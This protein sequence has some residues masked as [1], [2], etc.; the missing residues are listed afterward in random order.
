MRIAV[1]GGGLLGVGTALELARRG[2]LVDLFEQ[3]DDLLTQ[4]AIRNEG[5]IHLGYVYAN[6]GFETAAGMVQGALRFWPLLRRWLGDAIDRVP[7]SDGF[8][9]L[10]HRD[11]LVS[12][13]QV[14]DHARRVQHLLLTCGSALDYPGGPPTELTWLPA[15]AMSTVVDDRWVSATIQ[16]G[17]R[18]VA[19]SALATILR[20]AI[21][22][23][24]RIQVHLGARVADARFVDDE[25]AIGV[26]QS[27]QPSIRTYP[28]VVNA[29]WDG[30]LALD[31][32]LGLN[33]AR[34]RLWRLKY[35]ITLTLTQRPSLPS[36]T[37]VLGPFG[38]LVS[39]DHDQVYL[40]WYPA[41]LGG[42]SSDVSPPA[43]TRE[44]DPDQARA[45]VEQSI[46]GLG[47]LV[48]DVLEFDTRS[49]Q[50]RGGIIFARGQSDI[51]DP[52]SGLHRRDRIGIT[53]CRGWH[54]VD[55]GKYALA[56]AFAYDVADRICPVE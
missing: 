52:A 44:P 34:D 39:F 38:D 56:P 21:A 41:C 37:V 6:A 55:P 19:V 48:P 30:R 20:S 13:D 14:F 15:K 45:I 43:W 47:R 51:D 35:G 2:A 18:S 3:H 42:L 22:A 7:V 10:V 11:S 46:A 5:K 17:E 8:H 31:R 4:A 28:Q 36:I 26:R 12:A 25:V 54:S 33:L 9:Y 49:A 40:S 27:D 29:L 23:E 16:T 1:L 24:P 53:S 32:S 50:V